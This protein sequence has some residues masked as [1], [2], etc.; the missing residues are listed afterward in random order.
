MRGSALFIPLF[1]MAVLGC[2]PSPPPTPTPTTQSQTASEIAEADRLLAAQEYERAALLYR[3]LLDTFEEKGVKDAQQQEV[4]RKCTQAMISA[5]GFA[6]SYSL[7][8][9]MAIKKPES[10]AEAQRMQT[11]AKRMIL[12]QAQELLQ[13]AGVDLKEGHR[14]KALATARASEELLTL[15]KADEGSLKPVADFLQQFDSDGTIQENPKGKI[16]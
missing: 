8:E 10:K 1:C 6:S 13:Q 2:S 4:L 16:P 11:R 12:Q 3:K 5:G 9:E 7:W 14:S 15:V